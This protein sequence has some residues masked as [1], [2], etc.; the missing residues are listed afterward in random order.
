MSNLI[1]DISDTYFYSPHFD[2]S[3]LLGATNSSKSQNKIF[4]WNKYTH[5]NINF[6]KQF[7]YKKIRRHRHHMPEYLL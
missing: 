2:Q 3:G 1:S 5:K 4:Q 6:I 7:R